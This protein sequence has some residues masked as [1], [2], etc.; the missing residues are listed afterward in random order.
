M[1][2]VA[3]FHGL[4]VEGGSYSWCLLTEKANGDIAHSRVDQY[5]FWD[6]FEVPWDGT[7]L[8]G[9]IGLAVWERDESWS[10]GAAATE[11]CFDCVHCSSSR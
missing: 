10:F 2:L 7:L 11:K 3:M 8:S 4:S 5:T 6:I 1:L 9:D